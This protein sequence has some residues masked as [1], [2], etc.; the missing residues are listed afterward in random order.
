MRGRSFKDDTRQN[1]RQGE[2]QLLIE[3]RGIK[4]N[5]KNEASKKKSKSK[6]KAKLLDIA[7]ESKSE[8]PSDK[9]KSLEMEHSIGSQPIA[10]ERK[11]IENEAP[12]DD[13]ND[14]KVVDPIRKAQQR[15]KDESKAL[16]E[17]SG[18]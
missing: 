15:A 3:P 4:S 14:V 13:L 11:K 10:K 18:P 9:S 7:E 17:L 1:K 12:V 2:S 8:R 6:P 5:K 16:K